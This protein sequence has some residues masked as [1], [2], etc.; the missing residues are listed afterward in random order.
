MSADRRL[1]VCRVSA[2]FSRGCVL[3][4]VLAVGLPGFGARASTISD[5]QASISFGL[6]VWA[7]FGLTPSTS[8]SA[9]GNN[10]PVGPGPGEDLLDTPGT[11]FLNP[12]PFTLNPYGVDVTPAPRR[13]APPTSFTYDASDV[14]TLLAT[15]SGNISLAGVTRWAV[16]PDLGG[17]QLLLGDYS[18][19]YNAGGSRWELSNNIDFPG[20][21]FFIGDAQVTTGP[22]GVFSV[23]GNLIGAPF[24]GVLLAGS[25]GQDFGD[26]SFSAVPEPSTAALLTF[27]MAILA[28]HRRQRRGAFIRG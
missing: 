28:G 3:G 23:S 19:A 15:A 13:L 21:A 10:L 1:S 20:V 12:Q 5:A 24:L 7:S 22:N 6:S 25:V 9:A 27:G 11:G 18:L 17:G 14:P 8:I 4:V 16:L 2:I 26:F